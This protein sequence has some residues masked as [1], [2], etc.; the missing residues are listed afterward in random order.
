MEVVGLFS[1]FAVY[2]FTYISYRSSVGVLRIIIIIMVDR[3]TT[4]GRFQQEFVPT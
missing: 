3:R 1:R 4:K 2:L